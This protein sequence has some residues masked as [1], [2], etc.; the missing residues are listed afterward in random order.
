MVLVQTSGAG[1][2]LWRLWRVVT[3]PQLVTLTDGGSGRGRPDT[4]TSSIQPVGVKGSS[5]GYLE[6][7]GSARLRACE[8]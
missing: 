7:R 3:W 1:Q 8:Y 6:T 4:R 2:P 5:K